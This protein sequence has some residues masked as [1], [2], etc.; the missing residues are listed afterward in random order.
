MIHES[1]FQ[2]AISNSKGTKMPVVGSDDLLEYKVPYNEE[3]VK[4]FNQ[5]L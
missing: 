5:I 3:I 2:F 4:K 1:M